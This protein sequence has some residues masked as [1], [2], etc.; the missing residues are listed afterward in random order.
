MR[1]TVVSKVVAALEPITH[2]P[3]TPVFVITNEEPLTLLL[4]ASCPITDSVPSV[5]PR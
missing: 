2:C 1:S 4:L 5:A 3:A